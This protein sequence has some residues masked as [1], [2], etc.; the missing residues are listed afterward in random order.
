MRL[1]ILCAPFHSQARFSKE[2]EDADG[3]KTVSNYPMQN[4]PILLATMLELDTDSDR[5][6]SPI[7]TMDTTSKVQ[8]T[9]T[10][11]VGLSNALL[12]KGRRKMLDLVN[13]LHSTGLGLF[14]SFLVIST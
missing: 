9:T 14:F 13:R 5:P 10:T 7:S 6:S 4:H 11:S 1:R 12:S 8:T 2:R 3:I